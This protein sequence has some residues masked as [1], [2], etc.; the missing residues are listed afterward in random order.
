MSYSFH[1]TIILREHSSSFDF[2]SVNKKYFRVWAIFLEWEKTCL[3]A[4]IINMTYFL[5]FSWVLSRLLWVLSLTHRLFFQSDFYFR[6]RHAKKKQ[7]V[8]NSRLQIIGIFAEFS[9][10]VILTKLGNCNCST[11]G[12]IPLNG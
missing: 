9:K 7:K 2:L 5:G 6:C 10:K 12:K 4:M 1:W 3:K 11:T 8:L